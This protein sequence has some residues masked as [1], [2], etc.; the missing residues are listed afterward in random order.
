MPD[1]PQTNDPSVTDDSALAPEQLD[2]VSGGL[3]NTSS[4]KVEHN[5]TITRFTGGVQNVSASTSTVDDVTQN[6]A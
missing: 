6:T 1:D 3:L 5:A 4:D 2:R